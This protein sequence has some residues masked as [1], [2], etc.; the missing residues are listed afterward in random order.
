MRPPPADAVLEALVLDAVEGD[1]ECP[2]ERQC[3]GLGDRCHRCGRQGAFEVGDRPAGQRDETAGKTGPFE[4]A[5]RSGKGVA[6]GGS[7]IH[8]RLAE[9]AGGDVQES[10]L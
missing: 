10:A 4:P 9:C 6:I 2:F 5:H 1:G 7:E 3:R 8:G